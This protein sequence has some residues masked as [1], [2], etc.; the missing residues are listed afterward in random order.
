M[1]HKTQESAQDTSTEQRIYA[2][3]ERE[4]MTK[5]YDGAKMM[6]IARQAGVSHSMLHYYYRDKESLF[7]MVLEEKVKTILPIRQRLLD[8]NLKGVELLR[9]LVEI[10]F[11]FMEANPDFLAFVIKCLDTDI[12]SRRLIEER[13]RQM[14]ETDCAL[15]G[16]LREAMARGE[17][18]EV[19]PEDVLLNISGLCHSTMMQAR[20][21]RLE[22]EE[23][24]AY[25]ERRRRS[26]TD[27]VLAA[28]TPRQG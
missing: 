7:L 24:R 22:D 4:F 19:D 2:A 1:R 11:D 9:G 16:S 18:R 21:F 3:A 26:T 12:V 28:L 17:I 23:R 15:H 20:F 25:L 27:F 8:Q 6:S 13:F 10:T 14:H 5:G